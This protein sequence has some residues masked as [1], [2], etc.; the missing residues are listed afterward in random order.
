MND[1]HLSRE[2]LRSVATG[3][4]PPRTFLDMALN[5]L[6]EF[7]PHCAAEWEAYQREL[8]ARPGS[9]ARALTLLPALLKEQ[10]PKAAAEHQAA[11]R[12]FKELMR[13]PEE[14][15]SARIAR[16]YRRFR[17]PTL[18]Q[19][20]ISECRSR[21]RSAPREAYHFADLARVVSNQTLESPFAR[22]LHVLAIGEMANA[23]RATGRLVESE[24]LF[25]S[26]RKL[27]LLGG[28]S[29]PDVLARLDSLEGSLRKDQRRFREAEEV[30]TRARF[31]YELAGERRQMGCVS[32]QLSTVHFQSGQ[33]ARALR[34]GREAIGY[35]DPEADLCLFLAARRNLALYL[36]EQGSYEEALTLLNSDEE[37]HRILKEPHLQIRYEWIRGKVALGLG[38]TASAER[39]LLAAREVFLQSKIAYDA[40]M[41][42]LDLARAYLAA[43][44]TADT[45]KLASEIMPIFSAEEVHREAIAALIL[46]RDA[47]DRE[48]LT[49]TYLRELT[50]FLEAA[51]ADPTL[52][53]DP[54]KRYAGRRDS[55]E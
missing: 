44:R 41:V 33:L 7:C 51:Q 3:G 5:H 53:F 39:H 49:T 50:A 37:R 45:K 52:R 15:R 21:V 27:T 12:D 10:L 2:L 34:L 17:T 35:F 13:L 47:A 9:Y 54:A 6:F 38:D 29:D 30:L 40:A 46:F 14:Q 55:D 24:Q 48:E 8:R 43:G 28:V 19:R 32:M 16:S 31:L 18:A 23:V 4:L 1:L 20:L 25:G 11:A 42:S 26:V 22:D 36:A